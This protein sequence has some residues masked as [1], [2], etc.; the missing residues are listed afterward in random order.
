MAEDERPTGRPPGTWSDDVTDW[1]GSA[2]L[3][4]DRDKLSILTRITEAKMTGKI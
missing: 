3:D 4:T 1:F 2:R